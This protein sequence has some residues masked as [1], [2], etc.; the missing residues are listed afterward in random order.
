MR[1]V[2]CETPLVTHLLILNDINYN[3][4]DGLYKRT[5]GI[6]GKKELHPS[7][8]PRK[9]TQSKTFPGR[10]RSPQK[11]ASRKVREV[12][13]VFIGLTLVAAASKNL[14]NAATP[15]SCWFAGVFARRGE[16]PLP[17]RAAARLPILA[18]VGRFYFASF[19]YNYFS[20]VSS[21]SLSSFGRE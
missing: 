18:P 4:K 15:P 13:K 11:K 12:R 5:G 9:A 21:E 16:A 6:F 17:I 20:T 1:V 3:N 19:S 14:L 2:S 10:G 7:P 8:R